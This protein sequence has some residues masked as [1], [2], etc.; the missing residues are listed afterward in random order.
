MAETPRLAQNWSEE[1]RH[2]LYIARKKV[3]TALHD[4]GQI[5]FGNKVGVIATFS[6][7]Y[8]GFVELDV[9]DPSQVQ[10]TENGQRFAKGVVALSHG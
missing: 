4:G 10:L 8:E 6:L 1:E 5:D 2:N 9:Q 3:L 7:I